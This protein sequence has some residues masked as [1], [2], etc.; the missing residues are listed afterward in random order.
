MPQEQFQ[1]I[2]KRLAE[3][4]YDDYDRLIQ[5]CDA[6]GMSIGAVAIEI[7]MNDIKRRYGSYPQGKW[8][9]NI[10]LLNYFST[11]AGENVEKLTEGITAK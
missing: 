9:K 10:E 7:R 6:I 8:D 4:V 5:L 11:K 3:F 1:F 2:K